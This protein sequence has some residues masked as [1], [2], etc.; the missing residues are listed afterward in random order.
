[1]KTLNFKIISFCLLAVLWLASSKS[2]AQSTNYVGNWKSNAP[3]AMMNNSLMKI[4]VLSTSD[5]N[6]FMVVS[7]DVPKKKNPAKYIPTDGNLYVTL[8]N[9]AIYFV[10]ISS[11]DSLKCYRLSDNSLICSLSRF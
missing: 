6:L 10:Y 7:S 9:T 4:K 5:P 2:F 1:M 8:K 11:N 3:V